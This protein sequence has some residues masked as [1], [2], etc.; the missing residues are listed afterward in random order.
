MILNNL[1]TDSGSS[2]QIIN[3]EDYHEPDITPIEGVNNN[4]LAFTLLNLIA[5]LVLLSAVLSIVFLYGSYKAVKPKERIIRWMKTHG[6]A[7]DT[8]YGI[9]SMILHAHNL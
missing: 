1:S 8:E 9:T 4:E 5:I 6:F 7:S 3:Q 2:Q